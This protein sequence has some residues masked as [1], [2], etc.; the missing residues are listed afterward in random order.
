MRRVVRGVSRVFR[1][2]SL[3]AILAKLPEIIGASG[4]ARR[5]FETKI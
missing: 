4:L 3:Q 5:E 1:E 2:K